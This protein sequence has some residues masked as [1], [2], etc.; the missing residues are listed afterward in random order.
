[1]PYLFKSTLS[2]LRFLPFT[3]ANMSY[4]Q[5]MA[6]CHYVS[7]S[8]VYNLH[9]SNTWSTGENKNGHVSRMPS[10][11]LPRKIKRLDP[12]CIAK[13]S[14]TLG[15]PLRRHLI[16]QLANASADIACRHRARTQCSVH[17]C[18]LKVASLGGADVVGWG[19]CVGDVGG[20]DR[21]GWRRH[22]K[23]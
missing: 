22:H 13:K 8:P 23:K 3:K 17:A 18:G 16:G 19:D 6:S 9:L 12:W 2:A 1:M 14:G 7:T 5:P 21:T 15:R 4:R 11:R 10:E 20:A